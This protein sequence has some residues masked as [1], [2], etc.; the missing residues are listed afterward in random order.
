MLDKTYKITKKFTDID[1]QAKKKLYV[2]KNVQ[3]AVKI[4]FEEN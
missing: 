2:G 4:V 3:Y 1:I